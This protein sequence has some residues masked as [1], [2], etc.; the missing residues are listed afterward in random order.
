MTHPKRPASSGRVGLIVLGVL[1]LLLLVG[2]GC[3][4]SRYNALVGG[5][6]KIDGAFSEIDNQYKRRN[7]LIPQLVETIK[8]STAF[9]E[10]VLTQVTEARASVGRLQLPPGADPAAQAEYLQAQQQLG[11]AIG[12]MMLVAER[13]PDLKSTAG[14]RDMQS[15]IEGT[16]NRITVARRDYIDSVKDF[17]IT[18]R[19]FPAN[20]IGGFF[21]FEKK[22]QLEAATEAEREVPNINFGDGE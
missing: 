18:L 15:Q 16:E 2:G 20:I 3:T 8:G 12:R 6:E 10:S 9:E 5:E 11:G 1:L 4:V 13:Y 19:K 14:F 22:P 17:N 7:D 21:G